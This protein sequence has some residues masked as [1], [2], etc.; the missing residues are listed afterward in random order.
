MCPLSIRPDVR[1]ANVI[2]ACGDTG[3]SAFWVTR[4]LLV[5]WPPV[6]RSHWLS[7]RSSCRWDWRAS[8]RAAIGF[9]RIVR[10]QQRARGNRNITSSSISSHVERRRLLWVLRCICPPHC[11]RFG[12]RNMRQLRW[13]PRPPV[14][15]P[16]AIHARRF[17]GQCRR[18]DSP[19]AVA[20]INQTVRK[21]VVCGKKKVL[22]VDEA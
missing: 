14:S 21:I 10:P 7:H 1:R 13:P 12:L 17:G 19:G 3:G 9:I 22:D 16:L 18:R 11:C 15:S 2:S 8:S 6:P 5:C 20:V 4:S